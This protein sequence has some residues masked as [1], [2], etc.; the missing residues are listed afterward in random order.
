MLERRAQPIRFEIPD[1]HLAVCRA[2]DGRVRA[3]RSSRCARAIDGTDDVDKETDFEALAVHV[4]AQG[5][6]DLALAQADEPDAAFCAAHD[7]NGRC[8][9]NGEGGNA[10]EVEPGVVPG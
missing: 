5:R 3:G 9:V 10:A 1:A 2:G 6:D 7:G 8:G 4:A